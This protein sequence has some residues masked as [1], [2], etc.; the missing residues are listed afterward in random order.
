VWGGIPPRPSLPVRQAGV[1]PERS[2]GGQFRS[3]NVRAELY[4]S[5]TIKLSGILPIDFVAQSTS[6]ISASQKTFT[7]HC[8]SG[9]ISYHF[10]P[11]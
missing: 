1:P 10:V 11:G 2:G 9:R 4:N 7:D 3:K 5:T 6:R 8:G